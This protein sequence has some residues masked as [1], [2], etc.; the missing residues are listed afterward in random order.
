MI[1]NIFYVLIL[2]FSLINSQESITIL[3]TIDVVTSQAF[4]VPAEKNIVFANLLKFEGKAVLFDKNLNQIHDANEYF[5]SPDEKTME[6][7]VKTGRGANV[8]FHV[9]DKI[10]EVGEYLMRI[11]VRLMGENRQIQQHSAYYLIR[12]SNPH[13]ASV[14]DLEPEYFYSEK[15]TFSFATQEYSDVNLYY[16]DVEDQSGNKLLSG[17]GPVITLDTLFSNLSLIDSKL[18]IKGYY[19]DKV[20]EYLEN[21][22]TTP[23]K[24]EWEIFIKKPTLNEFTDWKNEEKDNST[25]AFFISVYSH[26]AMKILYTYTGKTESGFVVVKP[27]IRSLSLV[28]EPENLIK[29]YKSSKSGSWVFITFELNQEYL[30][31]LEEFAEISAKLK[32]KFKTQFNETIQYDYSSTLYK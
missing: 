18:K 22:N 13:I 2:F 31:S 15:K 27:D 6:K 25:K 9:K 20:F 30:D 10:D 7:E 29:S 32:V 23:K 16:W 12:V 8:Q 1:R 5:R 24:S 26:Q 4:K 28:S 17:K 14:V 19:A 21:G 11:D 3:D